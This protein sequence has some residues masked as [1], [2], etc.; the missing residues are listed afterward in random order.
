M[1][2]KSKGLHNTCRYLW[3]AKLKR[4][5][6]CHHKA[7]RTPDRI[8]SIFRSVTCYTS[9]LL[10]VEQD[11]RT[12]VVGCI[13]LICFFQGLCTAKINYKFLRRHIPNVLNTLCC[14]LFLKLLPNTNAQNYSKAT[15]MYLKSSYSLL[16]FSK[17]RYLFTPVNYSDYV[18]F[19]QAF[20]QCYGIA[21][22]F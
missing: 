5:S 4:H 17:V 19:E 10:S 18:G 12:M 22:Y 20:K 2:T 13:L 6:D 7:P 14:K 11:V 9:R 15:W 21:L 1:E 16:C 3:T 8:W